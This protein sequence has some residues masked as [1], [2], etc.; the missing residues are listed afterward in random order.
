M[1]TKKYFRYKVANT[2]VI[3]GMFGRPMKPAPNKSEYVQCKFTDK[4]VSEIIRLYATR[5]YTQKAIAEFFSASQSH[6]SD[7][8]NGRYRS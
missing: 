1:I 2:G 4:E 8:I 7:I 6:I 5:K 3:F